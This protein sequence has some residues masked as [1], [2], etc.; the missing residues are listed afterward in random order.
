M[1]NYFENNDYLFQDDLFDDL[2]NDLVYDDF[3]GDLVT[4]PTGETAA[5]GSSN[6]NIN[7][8]QNIFDSNVFN[9]S[10]NGQEH[11]KADASVPIVMDTQYTS[12]NSTNAVS[13]PQNPLRLRATSSDKNKEGG[14]TKSASKRKNKEPDNNT[15]HTPHTPYSSQSQD[16][17]AAT[18]QR[19]KTLTLLP[20]LIFKAF[21]GGDLP[22][23]REII[24]EVT[25]KD[26]ALKTPALDQELYGQNY[27]IDLFQAI[28]DSHPDAVWVAKQCKLNEE[29]NVIQCRV[30]FAGTRVAS[31]YRGMDLSGAGHSDYLYKKRNSSLLDEMDVATLSTVEMDSMRELEKLSKNLSVFFKGTLDLEVHENS[32][33]ISKFD[34]DWTI[35]SF[36]EAE[37]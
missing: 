20:I 13:N 31:V 27:V 3:G 22:K 37:I 21:N 7:I 2:L 6:A 17:H 28:Y 35:T 14:I 32:D 5:D 36:R 11:E 12:S 29:T 23:V 26:C 30:Y 25:I 19:M 8:N 34:F 16:D 33:K 15:P 24:R 9:N 18:V 1:A 4:F 10:Y